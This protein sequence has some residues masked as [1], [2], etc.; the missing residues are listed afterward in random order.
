MSGRLAVLV[1]V[2]AAALLAAPPA[3]A[4]LP[5]EKALAERYAPVVRL[6]EQPEEC[7]HG[8]PYEPTDVDVLFD[9]PTVAL[10]G[11]WK[12]TDS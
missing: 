4:D 12:P 1:A 9:E 5:S 11:P 2:G 7:G 3:G 8:E 10:R 6:M